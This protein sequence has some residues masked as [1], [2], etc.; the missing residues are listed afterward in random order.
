MAKFSGAVRI[1]DVNDFIT[2]AQACVLNLED[3]KA[4]QSKVLPLVPN[5]ASWS[6]WTIVL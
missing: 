4:P 5:S 6:G 3:V 1:G 2:P